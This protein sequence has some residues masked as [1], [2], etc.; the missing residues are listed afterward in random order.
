MTLNQ[1]R[2]NYAENQKIDSLV[3]WL[4]LNQWV[5]ET[6]INKSTDERIEQNHE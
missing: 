6:C 4:L 1:A 5:D 3:G 2:P